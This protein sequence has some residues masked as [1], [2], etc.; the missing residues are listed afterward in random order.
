[1]SNPPLATKAI[2]IAALPALLREWAIFPP[3]SL[4][5][6]RVWKV[7]HFDGKVG[8][9]RD[10]PYSTAILVLALEQRERDWFSLGLSE[11]E[12]RDGGGMEIEENINLQSLSEV[13]QWFGFTS[14][15]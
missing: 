2:L 8:E 1:M 11:R 13:S 6:A 12:G 4:D 10:E 5:A 14:N 15:R 9:D 7:L 3:S